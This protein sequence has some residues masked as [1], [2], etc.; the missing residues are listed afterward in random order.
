MPS[1][2]HNLLKKTTIISNEDGHHEVW[3]YLCI[4]TSIS[5][6]G[7]NGDLMQQFNPWLINLSNGTLSSIYRLYEDI[8]TEPNYKDA[9]C[10]T[11]WQIY[12]KSSLTFLLILYAMQTYRPLVNPEN[13]TPSAFYGILQDFRPSAST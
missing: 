5:T 10:G 7:H 11:Y 1:S 6:S 9:I 3:N 12:R 4:Y 2:Y 13:F 8:H